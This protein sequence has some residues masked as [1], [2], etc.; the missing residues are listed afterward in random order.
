MSTQ[1]N[2]PTVRP[3][4]RQHDESAAAFRAFSIYRDLGLE[5]S[6]REACRKGVVNPRKSTAHPPADARS[7][8]WAKW[9]K[10]H[11]WEERA[12]GWDRH[13]SEVSQKALD[14]QTASAAVDWAKRREQAIED[15]YQRG[16]EMIE[17][18]TDIVRSISTES[19][20]AK[21]LRDAAAVI[22]TGAALVWEAIDTATPDPDEDFDPQAATIEELKAFLDRR[23][24]K[25]QGRSVATEGP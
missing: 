11:Q 23:A 8:T 4:D 6:F 14:E 5:R 24:R 3:W 7:K 16:R 2:G 25:R 1:P 17:K 9:F 10:D 15:Q 12:R 13:N 18:A 19:A 22:N 20:D 21:R